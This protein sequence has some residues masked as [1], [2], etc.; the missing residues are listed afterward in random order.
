MALIR[1]GALVMRAAA[2]V[3]CAGRQPCWA[4]LWPCPWLFQRARSQRSAAH[5]RRK[6]VLQAAPVPGVST[7]WTR[8]VSHVR[9][10][11]VH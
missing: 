5:G 11:H 2:V 7:P 1:M 8:R 3:G 6:A 10:K 4:G 9:S